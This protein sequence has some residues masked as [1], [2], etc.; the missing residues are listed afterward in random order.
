MQLQQ[1]KTAEEPQDQEEDED[2]EELMLAQAIE[3]SKRLQSEVERKKEEVM[4]P[5]VLDSVEKPPSS[6]PSLAS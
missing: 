6:L 2:D 4:T 3:E 1:A 5:Q